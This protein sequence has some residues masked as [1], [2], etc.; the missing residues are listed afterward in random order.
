MEYRVL[1]RKYRPTNFDDLIGQEALVRTLSNAIRTGRIAHAFLLTGIRGIG[2]TTTARII[3]RA[4]NCIGE[5]G[6]RQLGGEGV[7]INPC[8]LCSNCRMIAEDRHVDVLEMD[9]ASHTGVGDIRELIETVRYLPTSARYKIYIIDEVHMLSNSAFN[10]LLKTLEEPPPHVKFVFAT[11]EARKIP[12]TIL[13][14]C[15]RFDL[16]RID[17]AMLAEHLSRICEKEQV[18]AQ[19]EALQLISVAAEGSVRDALSLLDQAI[20]SGN[21]RDGRTQVTTAA[22]RQMIGSADN[23][24]TFRLMETLL[25]GDINAALEE[26]RGQY[27]NGADPLLM[28]QD[29]LEA[30]HLVTRVK[31]APAAMLDIALPEH[32]RDAAKAM[33]D[34]ISMPVLARLW[35]ML[36]KGLGEVRMAP[37][38]LAALEML[39]VRIAYA[40]QL[41]TP[42][43]VIRSG[44]DNMPM[45]NTAMQSGSTQPGP[46]QPASSPAAPARVPVAAPAI[47][48]VSDNVRAAVKP[49]DAGT[50]EQVVALFESHR[51]VLLCTQL[52]QEVGLV[53]FEPGMIT[54]QAKSELPR[55]F[56]GKVTELLAQWTGRPWKI[57]WAKEG[58]AASL[59]EQEAARKQQEL[60]EASQHPLVAGVLEEFPGAKLVGVTSNI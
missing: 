11:T 24:A 46:L 59:H 21:E 50:F 8:G 36:L 12:V 35:Q 5:D 2:K 51:E 29:S 1:A 7:S 40:A 28:V 44:P 17:G 37:S 33:A 60:D 3:A 16:K 54:L 25:S 6:Q 4:L 15:Q 31:V 26:A 53:T 18:E 45:G 48:L 55:E 42:A 32:D 13:S 43:E 27:H 9:A 58:S 41:P 49:V 57:A 39:L 38:P 34:R 52:R 22:I 30:V 56:S 14:R 23:T 19:P 20:A 10:A 47:A